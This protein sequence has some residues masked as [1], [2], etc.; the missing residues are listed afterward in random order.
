MEV[1][2]SSKSRELYWKL[3]AAI[4]EK[5][6]SKL[7]WQMQSQYYLNKRRPELKLDAVEIRLINAT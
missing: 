1:Y 2:F 7:M 6:H 3:L 4:L 5:C